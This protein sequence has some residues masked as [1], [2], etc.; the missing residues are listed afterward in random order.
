MKVTS[1]QFLEHFTPSG[2]CG[3]GYSEPDTF[4]VTLD[5]GS[6]SELTVDIWYRPAECIRSEFMES[7]LSKF[8]KKCE[9]IDEA[10]AMYVDEICSHGLCPYSKNQLL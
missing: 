2:S 8:K 7:F 5:D 1:I 10:Y 3:T 6:V 9:N 4:E